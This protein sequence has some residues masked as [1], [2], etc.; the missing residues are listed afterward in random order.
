[1]KKTIY[2]ILLLLFSAITLS[3]CSLSAN[4]PVGPPVPDPFQVLEERIESE[5]KLRVDAE[6]KADDETKLRERWE[7]AAVGL[8]ILTILG[9]IAGTSLGSKGNRHATALST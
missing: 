9:F 4:E 6:L 5:R 3:S 8:G 2:I 7:L 1:M